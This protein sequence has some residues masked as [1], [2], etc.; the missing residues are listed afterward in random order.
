[1]KRA[2]YITLTSIAILLACSL[3]GF[4]QRSHPQGASPHGSF[5]HGSF[6]RGSSQHGSYGHGS[7][8]HGSYGHGSYGHG[9]YGHG[10]YGHGSNFFF[11]GGVWLGPWWWDPWWWGP[12][13]PYYY[14]DYT[15]PPVV[16]QQSP[17]EYIQREPTTEEPYYW[18]FCPKPEG[19]YPYVNKC[20]SGWMKV[21][22][23]PP[24]SER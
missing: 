23:A 6:S 1:M 11:S 3:S 10:S 2:I 14:P 18:Y 17:T 22:P 21:V 4:T 15:S 7:Y 13:Y 9:S 19:Y 8:G 12:S 16:I 24:Q 5:S 20:P